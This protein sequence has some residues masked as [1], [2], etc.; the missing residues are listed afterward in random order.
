MANVTINNLT[1]LSSEPLGASF[2]PIWESGA[3]KK[4]S[5]T[6]L[7]SGYLP[8][9]GGTITGLLKS[10]WGVGKVSF[11]S[12]YTGYGLGFNGN[13]ELVAYINGNAKSVVGTNLVASGALYLGGFAGNST[14]VIL[15][16]GGSGIL[17]RR[18]GVTAQEDQ[19]YGTYT[20]ASN[21]ERL[22]IRTAAGDYTIAAEAAGTGT[23]RNLVFDGANRGAFIDTPSSGTDGDYE[24]AFGSILAIL[25][26][27]GLMSGA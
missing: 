16:D 1:E 10:T 4:V 6:N 12:Q 27:H 17:A 15:F 19:I 26:S 11:E 14:D 5:V 24:A 21:Y 25:E 9:S 18:N 8:L 13:G 20:D 23:K 7:L 22:S 3:T 2:L